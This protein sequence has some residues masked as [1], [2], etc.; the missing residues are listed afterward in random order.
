MFSLFFAKKSFSKKSKFYVCM[1]DHTCLVRVFSKIDISK[2][3]RYFLIHVRWF[4]QFRELYK[5]AHSVSPN[6]RAQ[7]SSGIQKYPPTLCLKCRN[8]G[9]RVFR[10]PKPKHRAVSCI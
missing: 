5:M 6:T 1:V 2:T 10:F 8:A 3:N 9:F 4:G 7:T